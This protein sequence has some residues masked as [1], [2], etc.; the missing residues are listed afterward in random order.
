M[1]MAH[2]GGTGGD[3]AREVG[4]RHR[5]LALECRRQSG[6]EW[7]GREGAGRSSTISAA[8][9]ACG[10]IVVLRHNRGV[11]MIVE[12][13]NGRLFLRAGPGSMMERLFEALGT[14]R[15]TPVPLPPHP[16]AGTNVVAYCATVMDGR[17]A[18]CTVVGCGGVV[19]G[20]LVLVGLEGAA[21]RP[22]RR[23]EAEAYELYA[24]ASEPLP[25]LRVVSWAIPF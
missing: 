13:T 14:D 12:V 9:V 4:S 22:L 10:S 15:F 2:R 20:P 25:I 19:F 21:H 16:H 1:E 18:N 7:S 11:S 17:A 24:P 3:R 6:G 8:L 23:A 5:V